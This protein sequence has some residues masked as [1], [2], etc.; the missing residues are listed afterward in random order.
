MKTVR[1]LEETNAAVEI[2]EYGKL[3]FDFHGLDLLLVDHALQHA[4]RGLPVE[5]SEA[6]AVIS[7]LVWNRGLIKTIKQVVDEDSSVKDSAVL[8]DMERFK[9]DLQEH[10]CEAGNYLMLSRILHESILVTKEK[11]MKH[12]SERRLRMMR[13]ISKAAVVAHSILHKRA[14]ELCAIENQSLQL[15]S[16]AKSQLLTSTNIEHITF[17]NSGRC[18]AAKNAVAI[19]DAKQSHSEKRRY[20]PKAG[21]LVHVFSFGKQATVIDVK[22]RESFSSGMDENEVETSRY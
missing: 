19:D 17:D 8:T 11:V 13:E 22:R 6:M 4:R 15:T 12:G 7:E 14:R 21:D 9:L 1:L 18:V 16:S 10:V 5:G 20:L 3:G 2:L